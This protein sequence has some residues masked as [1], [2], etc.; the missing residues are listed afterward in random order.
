VHFQCDC[1]VVVHR[2]SVSSF[3]QLHLVH[4]IVDKQDSCKLDDRRSNKYCSVLSDRQ[5]K[6]APTTLEV[7]PVPVRIALLSGLAGPFVSL[8]SLVRLFL[9]LFL[10][11][12]RKSGQVQ[13]LSAGFRLL[14]HCTY[15]L[16]YFASCGIHCLLDPSLARRPRGARVA[17]QHRTACP[18]L[19]RVR[20]PKRR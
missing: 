2:T 17:E 19:H 1:L 16:R 10:S 5:N 20:R 7:P 18:F 3:P 11:R 15:P 8:P 12:R 13:L 4:L 14:Y 6:D 9:S